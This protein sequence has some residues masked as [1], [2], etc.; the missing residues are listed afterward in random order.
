MS[1]LIVA[2]IDAVEHRANGGVELVV[3]L[4]ARGVAQVEHGFSHR[5]S[6]SS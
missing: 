6:R 5:S 2:M 3:R 1:A 4:G